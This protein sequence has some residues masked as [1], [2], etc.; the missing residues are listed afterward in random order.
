MS[1][2]LNLALKKDIFDEL[3]NFRTNEIPIKKNDWWRKRLMDLDTGKFK[4]FDVACVSSGSSDKYNYPIDHIELKGD[5]YIITVV[6]PTVK[7]SE[8]DFN[9]GYSEKVEEIVDDENKEEIVEP[10]II[11]PEIIEPV[12]I[13]PTVVDTV[14]NGVITDK[15]YT[16]SPEAKELIIKRFIAKFNAEQKEDVSDIKDE[17]MKLIDS[18]CAQKDVFVVNMPF[19]TIRNNGQIIGYH[20]GRRLIADRDSDVRIDFKKFELQKYAELSDVEFLMTVNKFLDDLLDGSY[21]FINQKY[22]GFETTHTGEL[23]LKIAVASKKKYLFR[24]YN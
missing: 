5:F 3:T 1:N 13:N 23:I 24:K 6:L 7:E 22:C 21:V 12:Q 18:F 20:G 17:T 15:K 8:M 10:E 19:V 2:V 9:S 4:N 14:G 16:I 11:E